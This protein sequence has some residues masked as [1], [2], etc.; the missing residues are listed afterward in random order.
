MKR[1]AEKDKRTKKYVKKKNVSIKETIDF[2][3]ELEIIE[4]KIKNQI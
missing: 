2:L 4:K 1:K 3:R